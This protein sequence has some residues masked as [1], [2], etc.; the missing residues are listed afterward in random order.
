[1]PRLSR[2]TFTRVATAASAGYFAGHGFGPARA[3]GP[4]DKLNL[5]VIGVG[6]Q[7]GANIRGVAS[8]N[9]VAVCDVDE[10]RAGKAFEAGSPISGSCSTP[11]KTSSTRS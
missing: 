11:S 5:A 6:G 1:M 2:R 9:I 8:Q 4:N 3:E 7:A 10:R